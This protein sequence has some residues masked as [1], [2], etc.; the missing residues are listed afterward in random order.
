MLKNLPLK[1]Y[2]IWGYEIWFASTHPNGCQKELKDFVKGDYP[3]LGK[4]IQANEALSIQVHPDDDF[5]GTVEHCRGKN[6]CWYILEAQPGAKLVYGID[7][8]TSDEEIKSAVKDGTL[9][10]YLKYVEVKKGD[11]VYIPAGTVHAIGG[12]LRLL[13]IQQ[14]SDI[15]YRLYDYNRGRECHV[16]K[17]VKCL[18]RKIPEKIMQLTDTFECPYFSLEKINMEK[19][20]NVKAVC[21]KKS[22]N[23]GNYVLFFVAEGNFTVNGKTFFTEES[24]T[25]FPGEELNIEVLSETGSI[26]KI[27]C[28]TEC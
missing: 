11:L 22:D 2:K 8:N 23:P 1:F 24:F 28:K 9:E 17:A 5:A 15:T 27:V 14:S 3:L 12:G 7:E 19:N 16:E 20:Q 10:K 4:V 26:I 13:E 25:A 6:E 21:A 18:N